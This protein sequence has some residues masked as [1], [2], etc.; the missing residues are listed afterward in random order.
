MIFSSMKFSII[1][2]KDRGDYGCL[3]K[4]G[5]WRNFTLSVQK[6]SFLNKNINLKTLDQRNYD[7]N[8]EDDD[9]D[10]SMRLGSKNEEMNESLSL[11]E[12]SHDGMPYFIETS[13][14]DKIVA[15]VVGDDFTMNCEADGKF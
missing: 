6:H 3:T 10:E 8:D 14:M 12:T 9:E 2:Q 13:K 1:K 5:H 15:K 11:E 4:N 7:D